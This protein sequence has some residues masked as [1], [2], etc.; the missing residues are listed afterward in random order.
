MADGVA[1]FTA[2]GLV[3]FCAAFAVDEGAGLAYACCGA[4]AATAPMAVVHIPTL[5]ITDKTAF[6]L[7]LCFMRNSPIPYS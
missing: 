7:L 6:V 3:G 5:N 1:G 4:D 2:G